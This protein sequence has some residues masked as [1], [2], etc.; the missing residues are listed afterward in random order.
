MNADEQ[1]GRRIRA[2]RT[3][4]GRS[5]ADLAGTAMSASYLSMIESG[6]R[7]ASPAALRHLAAELETTVEFLAVGQ[8]CDA[9]AEADSTAQYGLL[10]LRAGDAE[11]T[12]AVLADLDDPAARR[13]RLRALER[14]GRLDE[15][16]EGHEQHLKQSESGSLAWAEHAV[17][18]VRCYLL[19]G[20]LIPAAELGE[21]AMAAF[22]ERDLL[23]SDDAVRL[24]MLLAES[25][26]QQRDQHAASELLARTRAAVEARQGVAAQ[27]DGYARAARRARDDGRFREAH[28]LSVRAL[29]LYGMVDK[30]VDEAN[31]RALSGMLL[32][33]A[34]PERLDE[35][36]GL[37]RRARADLLVLD[38][39]ADLTRCELVLARLLVRSGG[40]AEGRTLASAALER[41][42]EAREAQAHLTLAE[43]A[44]AFGDHTEAADELSLATGVLSDLLV[45]DRHV[46]ECWHRAAV[47]HQALGAGDAAMHAYD[48]ALRAAGHTTPQPA[49]A[50]TRS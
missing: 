12:L 24:A 32:A 30:Q 13:G 6:A 35:A 2:L 4:K 16:T 48:Q 20:D 43:A 25:R 18:L 44:L 33:E 40:A 38:V 29:A 11:E 49:R 26:A 3:A 9:E 17:D 7:A 14:L 15:A 47:L 21:Q 1:A 39:P 37:L 36:V 23:W 42:S 50:R 27:A 34:E 19:C 10:A 22:E 28:T 45:R 46:V 31:L 41:A 5:Q 8:E